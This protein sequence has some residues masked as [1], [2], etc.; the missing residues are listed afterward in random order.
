MGQKLD[1]MKQKLTDAGFRVRIDFNTQKRPGEKYYYYQMKGVPLRI[2]FGN[3]DLQNNKFVLVVRAIEGKKECSLD[4]LVPECKKALENYDAALKERAKAH[5]KSRIV[6]VD[7][8]NKIGEVL[9]QGGF[10]R[11]PYHTMG[12]EGAEGAERIHD[13]CNAEIRGYQPLEQQPGEGVKCIVTGKP[14]K[15]WAYVARSY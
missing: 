13:L 5:L 4:D 7:D 9:Q 3:R 2:D 14:A 15:Y 1:E 11:I 8:I 6:D 10:A 12:K